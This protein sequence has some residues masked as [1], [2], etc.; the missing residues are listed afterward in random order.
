MNFTQ[1]GDIKFFF[2]PDDADPLGPADIRV[3]GYELLRDPGFETAV[4]ISLFTDARA[5]DTDTLP[6]TYEDRRGYFGS[7]LEDS[8]IGSKLWL[9]GRSKIDNTTLQLAEQYIID[10]LQWMQQS[11]R[12]HIER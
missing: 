7:I 8:P 9:L 4:L 1:E 3:D 11:V 5:D 6:D 10:A 2:R 12:T